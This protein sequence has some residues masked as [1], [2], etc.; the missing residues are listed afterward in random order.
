MSFFKICPCHELPI[1]GPLGALY[2]VIIIGHDKVP[3]FFW[4]PLS[5]PGVPKKKG[6][7]FRSETMKIYQR[8]NHHLYFSYMTFI[9]MGAST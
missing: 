9:L 1:A 6:W 7:F 3:M 4:G 2:F 5:G 8:R